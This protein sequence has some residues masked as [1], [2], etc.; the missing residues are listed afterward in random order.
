M[1]RKNKVLYISL[2][3]IIIL[4][5]NIII[6]PTHIFG[7]KTDWINQH[8]IFPDYFRQTFYKT[9]DLLPNFAPHIGAGQNIFNFSYYGLLSPIILISYLFPKVEMT[10][11]III[12]NIILLILSTILL[13]YFLNKHGKKKDQA[14]LATIILIFSSSLFFHFHRHFMFVNYMPFLIA[15]LIGIDHYFD[16][17]KRTLLT[18][19]TF[20][21]IMTSYY[22]S[23]IGIFI[24]IIYGIYTY[25]KKKGKI[26]AK[27]FIID[28]IKFLIPIVVAILLAAFFLLP[29][30]H[31]ILAGRGSKEVPQSLLK[32]I[33]PTTNIEAIVYDTYSLGLTAIVIIALLHF[34]TTKEKENRF[35]S[36][37]LIATI[38]LP[39]IIYLLNG[40]LYI[41]NKIFIPFLPIMGLILIRFL[42]DLSK[43]KVNLKKLFLITIIIFLASLLSFHKIPLYFF[44]MD[45]LITFIALLLYTKKEKKQLFII[46]TIIIVMIN[47]YVGQYNDNYVEKDFLKNTFDKQT[48]KMLSSHLEEEK[49]MTRSANLDNVLYT[50]NKTISPKY[51]TTSIYSSTFHKDYHYFQQQ[52][53]KN[54]LPNRNT[55]MLT[56]S[57]NIMFQTFMGIKYTISS[58]KASIGYQPIKKVGKTY[59]YQNENVMPIGYA[60]NRIINR[61]D[62]KTLPYPQQEEALIANII[63]EHENTNFHFT[64]KSKE[65][66][67]DYLHPLKTKNLEIRKKGKKYIIDAKKDTKIKIPLQRTIKNEILFITLKIHNQTTCNLPNQKIGINGTYNKISCTE[68]EYQN[69]NNIFHYVLSK[70]EEWNEVT[71]TIGEG[72]YV[73]SDFKTYILD[74]NEIKDRVKTVDKWYAENKRTN[75]IEGKIYVRKDGYF[76]TSIPYDKGFTIWVDGKKQD[77]E[78]VN[79]AFLGF[80]IKKGKHHIKMTYHSPLLKEGIILSIIGLCSFII[81]IALDFKKKK[82][83]L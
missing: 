76:A 20:F 47:W 68:S 2:I 60:T 36:I 22:Y 56:Q 72:H 44:M 21:M 74:Y 25:I 55:L 46:P 4:A 31:V 5:I 52:V 54:P 34:A 17:K 40:G 27:E 12:S 37:A 19:S 15:G 32:L 9:K 6:D 81:I 16:S 49:Y 30:A 61:K 83:A 50:V 82:E 63:T 78:K 11:Y 14:F 18:I 39:I 48:E 79:T 3:I 41:R 64:G 53:F 70:N 62:L 42:N 26:I 58:K 8:T 66:F 45:A 69:H 23:I 1:K 7:S 51:Y 57:N 65:I 24:F 80:P 35:L 71:I 75:E 33:T 13:F 38:T 43:K 59:L 29:T 77:F 28:G 67:Q 10:T 73:L